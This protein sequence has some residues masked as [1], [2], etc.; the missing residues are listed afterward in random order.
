MAGIL[1]KHM[2]EE[3]IPPKVRAPHVSEALDEV[4]QRCLEK[5]PERRY[6]TMRELEDDLARVREGTRPQGPNT[7]TLT[8][9]RPPKAPRPTR[10][11]A[12]WVG[13]AAA[14]FV[15]A[16][17]VAISWSVGR[18]GT[19]AEPNVVPTAEPNP[20]RPV[21]ATAEAAEQQLDEASETSSVT[22]ASAPEEASPLER[23]TA[24][25]KPARREPKP[26]PERSREGTTVILDP[27][28]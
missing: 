15:F 12:L 26:R 10:R 4:I 9:T 28:K 2:Y 14:F 11:T 18:S 13:L 22:P 19:G 20:A 7:L 6:Q 1:T 24:R 16:A 25:R 17:A 23:K 21:D 5:K 3:P 8:P 27:W